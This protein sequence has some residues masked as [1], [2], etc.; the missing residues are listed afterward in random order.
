VLVGLVNGVCYFAIFDVRAGGM[1]MLML[2]LLFL[3]VSGV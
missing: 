1:G 2:A 3:I